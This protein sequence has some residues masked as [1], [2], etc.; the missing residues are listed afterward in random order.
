MEPGGTCTELQFCTPVE[1]QSQ[2]NSCCANAVAG[3]EWFRLVF[4]VAASCAS[5]PPEAAQGACSRPSLAATRVEPGTLRS[6]SHRPRSN[7]AQ[8]TTLPLGF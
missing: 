6:V 7:R 3:G 8:L 5:M 4:H 2:S 1:D